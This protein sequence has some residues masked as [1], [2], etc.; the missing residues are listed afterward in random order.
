MKIMSGRKDTMK[1]NKK[2]V[3]L[4]VLAVLSLTLLTGC[5]EKKWPMQ[6]TVVNR[7]TCPIADI[8]LSL[9]SEEDWG[10]N[11]IETVLEEGERV[12][13]DLGEY[14]EE[15]LNAGFILQFYGE[16]D[17]PVNPDYE[18]SNPFF[19]DNGDYF[20]LAPA[21]ISV[22]VFMD[23][24][25]DAAEYDQKIMELYDSEDDG[26]GDLIPDEGEEEDGR[27]DLI[28]DEETEDGGTV[29]VLIGGLPFTNMENI[30]ADNNSDGTYYYADIT[31]DGQIIVVNT[32]Q[33]SSLQADTQN[34]EDYLT[35]CALALAEAE[36]YEIQTAY[37]DDSLS[38]NMSY[39]VY[40]ISYLAGG[41]EDIRQWTVFAMDTDSYTYLYGFCATLDGAEGMEEVYQNIFMN[42]YLS[43]EAMQ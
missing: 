11:R 31:E 6:V 36:D 20:I 24:G 18:A 23:T 14:T 22:A 30:Q 8:R 10:P 21:D 29:P 38:A 25:Y 2:L 43:D 19:F 33:E 17:E 7:T 40:V 37:E 15:E 27:G 1:K 39:P 34:L 26:R 32:V 4:L 5:G 12:E 35:A 42:L 16:D 41:G 3:S 9:A 13:I 28:S